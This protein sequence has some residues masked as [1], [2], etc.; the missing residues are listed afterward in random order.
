[1]GIVLKNTITEVY[2][3]Y[4]IGVVYTVRVRNWFFIVLDT[5]IMSFWDIYFD[6]AQK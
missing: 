6:E 1:M 2:N 3:Y 5:S 4:P